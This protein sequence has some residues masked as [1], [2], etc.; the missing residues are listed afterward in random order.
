MAPLPESGWLRRQ[1]LVPRTLLACHR[2]R[3]LPYSKRE[4]KVKQ[5][6]HSEVLESRSRVGITPFA[7]STSFHIPS[8]PSPWARKDALTTMASNEYIG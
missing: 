8:P 3:L 2:A 5:P 4:H 6:T 1:W 7:C